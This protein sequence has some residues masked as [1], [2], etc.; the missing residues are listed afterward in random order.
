MHGAMVHFTE[1]V[2][3]SA[4]GSIVLDFD[5]TD[6][7][8]DGFVGDFDGNTALTIPPALHGIYMVG[9]GF[10]CS[11]AAGFEITVDCTIDGGQNIVSTEYSPVG[12]AIT[13]VFSD[14]GLALFDG[15]ENLQVI[16]R[17]NSDFDITI[18]G[19]PDAERKFFPIFW[20]FQV[21]VP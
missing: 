7:D 6:F 17:N 12:G 13:P 19:N 4:G 3:I 10:L 20:C 16:I 9:Y 11:S 1:D 5:V 18:F 2:T 8:T 15:D 14:S 21:G